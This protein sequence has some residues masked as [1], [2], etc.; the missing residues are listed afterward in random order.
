MHPA[1]LVQADPA[2]WAVSQE[3][4]G[5]MTRTLPVTTQMTKTREAT[6]GENIRA[7][8][9][10]RWTAVCSARSPAGAGG[11]R[12]PVSGMLGGVRLRQP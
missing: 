4:G 10:S 12:C 7:F 9:G 1:H 6:G 11:L 2:P 5:C 8:Q 3:R